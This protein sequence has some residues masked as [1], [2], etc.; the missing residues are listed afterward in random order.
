MTCL[1]LSFI[2]CWCIVSALTG[3]TFVLRRARLAGIAIG[4]DVLFSLASIGLLFILLAE[5]AR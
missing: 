3:T 5:K 4:A 1:V 2:G